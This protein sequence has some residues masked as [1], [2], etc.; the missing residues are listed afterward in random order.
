MLGFPLLYHD[1]ESTP[2]VHGRGAE[3]EEQK[4]WLQVIASPSLFRTS[5]ARFAP[6]RN[7]SAVRAPQKAE[8][9]RETS[10][11]VPSLSRPSSDG[12]VEI[13]PHHGGRHRQTDHWC[14]RGCWVGLPHGHVPP[15]DAAHAATHYD[16]SS[17]DELQA[18]LKDND[19]QQVDEVTQVVHEQPVVDIGRRL[20]GEGPADG[21]QPAVP[22]PGQDNKEQP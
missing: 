2:I 4:T 21:D 9:T 11:S 19:V 6:W 16:V 15:W 8:F 3:Q 22:V 10:V 7:H 12:K 14:Y 20:V 17:S 5:L 13:K 18:G 1:G